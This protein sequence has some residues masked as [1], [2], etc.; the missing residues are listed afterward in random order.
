MNELAQARR[1]LS[2][3]GKPAEPLREW[4]ARCVQ[5]WRTLTP[6]TTP[7][8]GVD[9]SFGLTVRV[10]LYQAGLGLRAREYAAQLATN[11]AT[12]TSTEPWPQLQRRAL[13]AASTEVLVLSGLPGAGKDTWLARNWSGAVISLDALRVR[14]SLPHPANAQL[15]LDAAWKQAGELLNVQQPFAWNATNLRRRQ[16]QGLIERL[17]SLGARV[18]LVAID[19]PYS[20]VVKQNRSRTE[21][22]SGTAW[23]KCLHQWE[24]VGPGEADDEHWF[25]AGVR[26]VL[27]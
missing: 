7:V 18:T 9:S 12:S 6:R 25:E 26:V 10:G 1:V 23:N 14:L 13:P 4:A 24:C 19:A 20:T 16:R 2:T 11:W 27:P 15:V 5:T 17:Q 8:T 3:I 22:L 21:A